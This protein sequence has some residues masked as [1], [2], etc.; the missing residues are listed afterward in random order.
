M[1]ESTTT[2]AANQPTVER[3]KPGRPPKEQDAPQAAPQ[4]V[5]VDPLMAEINR[6]L[7]L[8]LKQQ[9]R[10]K[11]A[12]PITGGATSVPRKDM[13]KRQAPDCVPTM[14]RDAKGRRVVVKKA[15][16]HPCWF[17]LK[18]MRKYAMQGYVPNYYE[19]EPTMDGEDI[20]MKI[21]TEQHEAN[22]ADVKAR[23]DWNLSEP[24]KPAA[25]S[26]SLKSRKHDRDAGVTEE[27]ESIPSS[28][29][30]HEELLRNP[31]AVFPDE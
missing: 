27:M 18:D 23:S 19:G 4:T 26:S 29:P 10:R 12:P 3:R 20:L 21:P 25:D 31:D 9:Q 13:I 2:V 8:G 11:A 7:Q 22:L 1:S 24:S 15:P 6:A 5:P 17:E 16:Y 14:G 30:R 28:D